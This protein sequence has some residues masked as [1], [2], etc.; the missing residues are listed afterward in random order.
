MRLDPKQIPA[1]GELLLAAEFGDD[2]PGRPIYI[3]PPPD[4][5]DD[6]EPTARIKVGAMLTRRLSAAEATEMG[7]EV[8]DHMILADT[9]YCSFKE[10]G[11]L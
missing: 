6:G 7:I 3:R 10:M 11:R 1:R 9:R 4:G 5:H 2:A 8:L